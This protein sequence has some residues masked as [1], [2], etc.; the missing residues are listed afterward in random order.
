MIR[1]TQ[2]K[3]PITHT[4]EQLHRKIAKG[5]RPVSDRLRAAEGRAEHQLGAAVHCAELSGG[6][7]RHPAGHSEHALSC[8]GDDPLRPAAR[9][10][11][12][13]LLKRICGE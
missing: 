1:I 7:H 12:G 10:V 6:A 8:D 2:L 4:E 11:R 13:H 3:L 5:A 9:R